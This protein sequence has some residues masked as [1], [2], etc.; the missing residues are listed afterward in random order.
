METEVSSKISN[1]ELLNDIELTGKELEAYQKIADGF[2]T[3]ATLPENAGVNAS[4][5][6]F[7]ANKYRNSER[8]CAAFLKQLHALKAERGLE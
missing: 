7:Q 6:N 4:L 8:D 2:R 3:L 1:E 5:H